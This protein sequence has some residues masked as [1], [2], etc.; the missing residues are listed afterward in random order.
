MKP[1]AAIPTES[2]PRTGVVRRIL[3]AEDSQTT[4]EILKF[5]LTQWD[6][7]VDIAADEEAAPDALR[8][9]RYDVAL[10]IFIYQRPPAGR[11]DDY[12]CILS[13]IRSAG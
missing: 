3:V 5:L 2:E 12:P 4:H 13:F 11:T 8:R 1:V 9:N 6:L 7:H 10:L